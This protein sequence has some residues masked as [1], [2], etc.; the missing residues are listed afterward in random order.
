MNSHCRRLQTILFVSCLAA[1]VIF[2]T[3]AFANQANVFIYHRFGEDRYPSTNIDVDLFE[4]HLRHLKESGKVVMPLSDVVERLRSG[5][6]LPADAVVLTV[7]D[8]FDSFLQEAMPVLR[9]YGFPVTLFVNTDGVGGPGYL[10]WDQLRGLA[11]EGVEIGNHTATHDYLLERNDGE[12][13]SDWQQRVAGDIERAQRAFRRELGFRPDLFA[14]PYGEY[15][16]DLVSLVKEAGFAAAFAQQSGVVSPASDLYILPRFPMGGPF[17]SLQSFKN[18]AAMRP[19]ELEVV[20]PA[21]PVVK[22]TEPPVL[23]VRVP[24]GKYDLRRLQGF[25]QGDNR[26]SLDVQGDVVVVSAEKP[27]A[28]RRNKYTLTVPLQSGGG[29]AWFSHPWFRLKSGF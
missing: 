11:A 6:T 9:E 22:K 5:Q 18:K 3:L 23:T 28:G 24:P 4:K 1:L 27:L 29:W 26:L 2:P 13:F 21:S 10:D 14:Y 16:P 12:S 17:A 15:S 25:V 20:S 7:D 19:F 8:A